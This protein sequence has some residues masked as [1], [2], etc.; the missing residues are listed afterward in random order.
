MPAPVILLH[1]WPGSPEDFRAVLPL[2][3]GLEVIVPDLLGFGAAFDDEV[4]E[5]EASAGRHAERIRALIAERGLE[6][7]VLAGYDVGS[8]VAQAFGRRFGDELTGLVVTP[9]HPGVQEHVGSAQAQEEQWYQHLHRLPLLRELLDGDR[10][11]I[12]AYLGHFW[13]HW[14]AE[15]AGLAHGEA[16]ERVVD[17]YARPGALWASTAWYRD[18]TSYDAPGPVTAPT[19]LLWPAADPLYPRAWGDHLEEWFTELRVEDVPGGHF[20]PLEA[21]QPF[22]AAVRAAAG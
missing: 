19:T 15:G 18:N 4:P 16:F 14:A 5:G 11:A 17:A 21:A 22:A 7:P 2:L 3:D 12:A 8:R 10:G 1:G 9:G 20:V 6:R 13:T